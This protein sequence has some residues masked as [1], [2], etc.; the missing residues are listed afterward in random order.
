MPRLLMLMYFALILW[1]VVVVKSQHH[2]VHA[3]EAF[4]AV[5]SWVAGL[6]LSWLCFPTPLDLRAGR[7]TVSLPY[8]PYAVSPPS[9]TLS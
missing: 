7:A 3:A 8:F 4:T 9:M 1:L 2:W 6:Q 5:C